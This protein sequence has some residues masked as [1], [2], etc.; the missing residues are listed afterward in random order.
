MM[1]DLFN[2]WDVFPW[3]LYC[4]IHREKED[5]ERRPEGQAAE[6]GAVGWF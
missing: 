5:P 6:V 2:N 1:V 4:S 3:S